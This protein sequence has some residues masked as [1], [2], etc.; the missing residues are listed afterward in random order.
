MFRVV[1]V[2]GGV[3]PSLHCTH[4][5]ISVMSGRDRVGVVKASQ[6]LRNLQ[7]E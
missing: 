1:S 3:V 5:R 7:G 6:G 2:A 4:N